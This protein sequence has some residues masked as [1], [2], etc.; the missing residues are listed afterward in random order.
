MRKKLLKVLTSL[1]VGVTCFASA[2]GVWASP[3]NSY[4]YFEDYFVKHPGYYTT[5]RVVTHVKNPDLE[6][7]DVFG[8]FLY[9]QAVPDTEV[10]RYEDVWHP[11]WTETKHRKVTVTYVENPDKEVYDAYGNFLYYEAVPD[12]EVVSYEEV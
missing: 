2:Q 5:E 12:T 4:S 9:Y 8:N 6:V 11:G 7:H 3:K 1:M 10:V